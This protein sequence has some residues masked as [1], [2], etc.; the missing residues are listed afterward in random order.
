MTDTVSKRTRSKIMGAIK[1]SGNRST[2]ARFRFGLVGHGISG[3]KITPKNFQYAPDFVFENQ[4]TAIFIDGCF[5]HGCP[6][7]KRKPSSNKAY[8]NNKIK[9]NLDR[10]KKATLWF[11]KQGYAV[12][13]FWEHELT[14]DL[15]KCINKL[16]QAIEK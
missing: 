10:D 16:I 2:E 3:W 12:L 15:P 11:K 7:C 14:Q 5:W 9:G 1:S 4:K 8:W 6:T 13:R